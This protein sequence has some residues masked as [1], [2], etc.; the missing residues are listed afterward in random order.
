MKILHTSDW[1]IGKII[2]ETNLLEDQQ[3]IL[4]G[5]LQTVDKENP[6]VIIIAGDLYDRAI[7]SK[8]AVQLLDDVLNNLIIERKITVI[9]IAGNHDSAER[10]EFTSRILE[11]NHLY[12]AGKLKKKVQKITL[13]DDY[14]IVNFFLMPFAFVSEMRYLL[15]DESVTSF[16]DAFIRFTQQMHEDINFS[17]RNILITHGYFVSGEGDEEK[18][19]ES[20]RPL[21]IGAIETVHVDCLQDFDYVALGH[22]HKPQKVKK[23]YIR[24]SGSLMKYS[25]SEVNHRKS[26]VI[27][28]LKEKNNIEITLDELITK[29]GMNRLEGQFKDLMENCPSDVEKDAYVLITLT[30]EA[31]IYEAISHLKAIYPNILRLEYKSKEPRILDKKGEIE[32]VYQKSGDE[33]FN[34]FYLDLTGNELSALQ[35]E[36]VQQIFMEILEGEEGES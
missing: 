29:R 24:Y 30:D 11:K 3:F 22:I 28:N 8:E 34:D 26:V 25:F 32:Q 27:I 18:P 33:L 20:V 6:D 7:P 15:E 1:H 2:H 5:F 16:N 17:E 19:D 13:K 12:I 35:T 21:S 10:L 9:A 36:L 23:N 4:E 14:G 31:P